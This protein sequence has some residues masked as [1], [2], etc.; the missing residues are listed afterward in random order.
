[1]FLPGRATERWRLP[2]NASVPA[3][4]ASVC[5]SGPESARPGLFPT[6]SEQYVAMCGARL[7]F[8]NRRFIPIAVDI[9]VST[10][11][12]RARQRPA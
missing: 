4:H 5:S 3:V 12:D 1:V 7:K 10:T 9:G 8:A 2:N 11:A 6:E